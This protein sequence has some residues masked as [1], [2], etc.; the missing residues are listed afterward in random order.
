MKKF[1]ESRTIVA[2]LA[3]AAAA[4]L[5]VLLTCPSGET[6][7]AEPVSVKTLQNL[8]DLKRQVSEYKRSGRYDRDVA[9]VLNKAE[10]YVVRRAPDVKMAAIVLDIDETSLSNWAQIQANDYGSFVNGAC[11]LPQGP[12]GQRAWQRSVQGEPIM[13]TLNLFKAAKAKGVS[14]FFITG[15]MESERE[16]TEL[17]LRKAGYD[18]W[19]RLIM[20]PTGTTTRSAADYKAPERAK[21]VA[22]GFTIIAN[23]G[24]QP[25]DL[26][27]GNAE[28]TYLVP[29]PFY[30]IP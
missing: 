8:G 3:A 28:R 5:L 10:L 21:I 26:A 29:N 27:G 18:G 4:L 25:S 12:C 24:D 15:R 7:F 11:D 17:N 2:P 6:F 22:E 1:K 19:T 14:V 16:P 23:I 9:E 20:R 30:R 13:P